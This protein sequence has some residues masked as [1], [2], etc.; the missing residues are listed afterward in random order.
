[1]FSLYYPPFGGF[2][3]MKTCRICN[4]IK[5]KDKF[6]Y[7]YNS[8]IECENI[9]Q[10]ERQKKKKENQTEEQRECIRLKNRIFSE[11][12]R[13]TDK[14][15]KNRTSDEFKKVNKKYQKKWR[16]SEKCKKSALK[17]SKTEKR[18][19]SESK[20]D[21]SEKGKKNR[22]K[23]FSKGTP[24]RF[25]H[26]I[27]ICIVAS[28]KRNG[29]YKDSKTEILLGCTFLELY[30]KLGTKPEGDYELDHICPVAQSINQDEASK[31]QNYT[32]FQWLIREENRKNQTNG[33]QKAKN[34]VNHFLDENGSIKRIINDTKT[35]S[36]R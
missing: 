21:K 33:L 22:R 9:K 36:L 11:N 26:N 1:M 28:F 2:L 19:I 27:R 14:Y 16:R 35:I 34:F 32:N 25:S 4:I 23:M 12:Y 18:K 7:G 20:Y 29:H 8:C 5:E 24:L 13:K 31:L 6:R 10:K 17:Y 30:K 15:K 3:F